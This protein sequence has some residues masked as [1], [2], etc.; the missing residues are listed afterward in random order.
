MNISEEMINKIYESQIEGLAFLE[1]YDKGNVKL[2]SFMQNNV[3]FLDCD[4]V[5]FLHE[6]ITGSKSIRDENLLETALS[7]FTKSII[8]YTPINPT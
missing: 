1:N 2:E 3:Q 7:R 5:V 6:K 8:F 4:D